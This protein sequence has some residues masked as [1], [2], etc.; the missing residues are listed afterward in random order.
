VNPETLGMIEA[1]RANWDARTP[2][3]AASAFYGLDGSRDPLDWF[4]DFEWTDLGPLNGKHVLHL[5]C[6]LG[7]ETAVF[8]ERGARVT[9][10]DISGESV[11]AARRHAPGVSFVRS[12]VYGAVEALEGRTF[13]VVY[14]GKGAICYLPDLAAWAAVVAALLRPGGAVY[15]VE[16]HPLLNALGV[17]APPDG[18]QELLLR[19]DFLAGRGAIQRDST[20][21]YTDG[22]ALTEARVSY[23]WMHGTGEVLTALVGAGLTVESLRETE[24]LPWPRWPSMTPAP[25]GWFHLPGTEPRIPLMY[26]LLARKPRE[27]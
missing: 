20:Y 12:D 8:A 11:A 4:A 23:E 5:Q 21:T 18:S 6:H 15:V 13:D 22:P 16:F 3:H 27:S 25:G 7:T 26:A 1:N 19:N 10:L 17:V 2:I 9:G 24:R 14:T